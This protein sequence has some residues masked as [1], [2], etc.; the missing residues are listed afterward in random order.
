MPE[1][2]RR[3]MVLNDQ[4]AN[5]RLFI[6]FFDTREAVDEAQAEFE[7]MADQVS[8]D[9]RGRGGGDRPQREPQRSG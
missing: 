9:V 8:E 5:R 2:V 1:G 6:A 4:D 7:S 3:I